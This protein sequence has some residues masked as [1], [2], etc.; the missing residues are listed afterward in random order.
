[1]YRDSNIETIS[2]LA[3]KLAIELEELKNLKSDAPEIKDAIIARE[4]MLIEL[5]RCLERRDG[6]Y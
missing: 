2:E 6:R 4:K 3:S 5:K 1:M